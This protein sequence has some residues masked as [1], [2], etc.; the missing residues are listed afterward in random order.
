M[1]AASGPPSDELLCVT[2]VVTILDV[3]G[4]S[5]HGLSVRDIGEAVGML[6]TSA[7][8]YVSTL[9]YHHYLARCDGR[10]V[11]GPVLA[12]RAGDLITQLRIRHDA[13]AAIGELAAQLQR[14]S[15]LV[16]ALLRGLVGPA[17]PAAPASGEPVAEPPVTDR[18]QG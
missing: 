12:D 7:R 11:L 14:P 9:V 17:D 13:G 3:V 2:R 10:Y 6:P 18:R 8:H 5:P 1:R 15:Q 4:R 16:G